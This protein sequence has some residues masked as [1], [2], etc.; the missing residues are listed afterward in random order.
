MNVA[1]E[2]SNKFMMRSMVVKNLVDFSKGAYRDSGN[3]IGSYDI[4]KQVRPSAIPT[5]T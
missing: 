5:T 2:A 1:D 3:L 4:T